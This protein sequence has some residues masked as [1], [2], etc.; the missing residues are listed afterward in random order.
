LEQKFRTKGKRMAWG[1]SL[2][3][4]DDFRYPPKG[5]RHRGHPWKQQLRGQSMKQLW[6]N[7]AS[8]YP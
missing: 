7:L 8:T 4:G 1:W 6:T 5:S 2:E 3:P